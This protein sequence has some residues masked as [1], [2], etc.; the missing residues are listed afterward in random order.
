MTPSSPI[1]ITRVEK[2]DDQPSH[3][4]VVGSAAYQIRRQDAV[5]D[6]V[7]IIPDGQLSKRSSKQNLEGPLASGGTPRTVGKAETDSPSGPLKSPSFY[8][9]SDLGNMPIPETVVTR[10]DDDLAHGEIP[11]TKAA[12]IRKQDAKPDKT[13]V[14]PEESGR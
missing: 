14:V 9:T 7:E 3:G 2:V 12:E 11:G 10:V 5:P 1:P 8:Q 6:E 4:E 13:E